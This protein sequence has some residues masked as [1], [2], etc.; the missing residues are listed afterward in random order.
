M[1][2]SNTTWVVIAQRSKSPTIPQ[3][4]SDST[5]DPTWGNMISIELSSWQCRNSYVGRDGILPMKISPCVSTIFYDPV[6]ISSF[7][8]SRVGIEIILAIADAIFSDWEASLSRN[9][10]ETNKLLL[11]SILGVRYIVKGLF[12]WLR[13]RGM[14]KASIIAR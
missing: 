9:I 8:L 14:H 13:S 3:G 4:C 11:L 2:K 5:Q 12:L 10:G 6:I 7:I 1:R